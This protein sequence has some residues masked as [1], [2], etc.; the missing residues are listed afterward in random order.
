ML[1]FGK[2]A[3]ALSAMESLDDGVPA[4]VWSV[5]VCVLCCVRAA[6][7]GASCAEPAEL[8]QMWQ[9]RHVGEV[10]VNARL[11]GYLKGCEVVVQ[12]QLLL[13]PS[14]RCDVQ[15]TCFCVYIG[16]RVWFLSVGPLSP[17]LHTYVVL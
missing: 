17:D 5:G 3:H 10:T 7:S 15:A 6:S 16:M 4:V 14:S 9:Q 1:T 8:A 2:R 13:W 12:T 11:H